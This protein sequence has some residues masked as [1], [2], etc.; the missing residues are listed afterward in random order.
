MVLRTKK[1]T[2]GAYVNIHS[3]SK[4]YERVSTAKETDLAE[5]VL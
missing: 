5:R 4:V 1:L 3:V 2:Y